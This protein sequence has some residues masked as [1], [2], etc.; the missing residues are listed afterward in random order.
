MSFSQGFLSGRTAFVDRVQAR[1][2]AEVRLATTFM[3]GP[4]AAGLGSHARGQ[5]LLSGVFAFGGEPL[6]APGR[7]IWD[8]AP[9]APD[10]RLFLAATHGF[11]WLGDLAAV[12]DTAARLRAQTWTQA[13]IARFGR[14][15]G[16]GWPADIA[17]RRLMHWIDHAGFLLHGQDAAA[18]RAVLASLG[19]QTIYLSRR[20]QAAPPGRARIEV[21]TGLIRGALVQS[22]LAG[23][24]GPAALALGAECTAA[25]D[26]GGAIASRNPEDLLK[27]FGLLIHAAALLGAAGIRSAP[28]HLAAIGRI[29]PTLRALRHA[30][31]SL[32][33]FHG[34]GRGAV[35]RLDQALVQSG[36]RTTLR[37]TLAMGFA[38]LSLGR[39]TVIVDAA[40]PPQGAAS[41]DAHAS[42]LAFELVSGRRPVVVNCGSG[43][44]FGRDWSR[45]ARQTASHSTLAI[46]G[47]SSSRFGSRLGSRFGLRRAGGAQGSGALA[48]TP[49]L[50][51]VRQTAGP[52]GQGLFLSHD[53][54]VTACGLTHVRLL[55]L[56]FDGRELRGE[57]TL[58]PASA[59]QQRRLGRGGVGFALRFHLHPDVTATRDP[60][61][62]AVRL[63]LKSGEAWVFRHDG[64]GAL[65][66]EPSVYLEPGSPG[67][68]PTV[69][70]VLAA[71]VDD[72][73]CRLRWTLAKTQDTPRGI[74]D[75][76][77]G[78]EA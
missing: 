39:S 53:G 58:G 16:P 40:A 62:G 30:D 34:G 74:R 36:V 72:R 28:G 41:A 49:R 69:Q 67:P 11:D 22:A 59:H 64:T 61:H 2:A 68:R 20:W 13:W 54:Y 77:P 56:A 17:A 31:G 35:G 5:G 73:A 75:L 51:A 50:V 4:D 45:A 9:P 14:G 29:A 8:V 63:G 60:A 47:V 57:D 19:A 6:T 18:R 43:A 48:Q 46:T 52:Q 65:A 42:T 76:E 33:R 3:P 55:D 23:H 25:V 44:G 78:P 38:R 26:A 1:R 21:L 70:I 71:R 15:A 24:V 37:G 10:R 32:A 66:L 27:V 7:A 12:G